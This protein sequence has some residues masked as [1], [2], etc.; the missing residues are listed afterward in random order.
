KSVK[1]SQMGLIMNGILKVPMQFFILLV[2]VM[3]FVFYQFN[4]SPLNFNPVATD[5][6]LNSEYAE[7]YKELE[8]K[9]QANFEA[10]QQA[11]YN[12]TNVE[13]TADKTIYQEN[14]V[15]L[16]AQDQVYREEAK[17]LI[18]KASTIVETNDKDYVFIH[19]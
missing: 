6:V 9:Q 19:F 12:F 8:A 14:I 16:D 7:E 11:I 15:S 10:K 18:S 4:A 1:Q 3:V 13:N 5:T 2:G 17:T